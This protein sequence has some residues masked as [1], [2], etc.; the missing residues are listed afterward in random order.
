VLPSFFLMLFLLPV[1]LP[2]GLYLPGLFFARYFRLPI[3]YFCAFP[4]SLVL[5]FHSI[6]WLGILHVP[7]TLWTVL[8]IPLVVTLVFAGL[9]RWRPQPDRPGSQPAALVPLDRILLLS[10]IIPA[11]ALFLRSAI[12]PLIGFDTPFRWDFL[13]RKI[14]EL[15]SF[16]F[17][18][19]LTPADYRI[20]FYPD[21]IPPM[22]SFTHWWMY[23]SAGQ[24]LP[25]LIALFVTA[26]FVCT[27]VFTR[28]AAESL[29]GP[30]AGLLAAA[31][32][33]ASPLFLR[34]V[35]LGQETGLTALAIAAMLCFLVAQSPDLP[36]LF[37]AG[38]AAAL[39]A[40]SRE[41]GWIALV[42]GVIVLIWRRAPHKHLVVFCS[43]AFAAAIPWYLRNWMLTG[44]PVYSL[45]VDGFPV[46]PI[47]A[48][49]MQQYQSILGLSRWTSETWTSLIWLLLTY[50]AFQIFAGIP[51]GL[52]RF[53]ERG[54]LLVMAVILSAVWVQSVGYTSGGPVI[55]TRVLSPMVVVLS[56]A[57]AGL[58]AAQTARAS[59]YP[60]ILAAIVLVQLWTAAHAAFFPTP[61][62]DVPNAQWTQRAFQPMSPPTEFQ[63]ADGFA[64]QIPHGTRVLTDSAY[65]H[66]AL[67]AKGIDVVPVWSP[68]VRFIFTDTPDDAERRLRELKI[69]SVAYYPSSINTL[70]LDKASPFYH[71]LPHRWRPR[72]QVPGI[73]YLVGPA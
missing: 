28:Y 56:I 19:P 68:E 1:L 26:Q 51:G 49:I 46:N 43:T 3:P 21:G 5:L 11:A 57:A 16:S 17:Y 53:R 48:A 63:A 40:L 67:Q 12:S 52:V 37:A 62:G 69:E 60:A 2:L 35:L 44:N 64:A 9:P 72:A 4:L 25:V 71:A 15:R 70:Y 65:F 38:L 22:I 14:L 31:T 18:P 32:L 20:Y 30:R 54:Y 73:I 50:A 61:P 66:A 36:R 6:F 45:S 59:R 29:F 10:P 47:H 34:S 55:S 7:L 39:C 8:P 24:Y 42:C 33:A 58:L 13:G 41:Y 23:A 27:L